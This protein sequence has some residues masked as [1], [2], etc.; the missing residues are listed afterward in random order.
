M[1]TGQKIAHYRKRAGLKQT[2]LAEMVGITKQLLYKY[3]NDKVENMPLDKLS[4]I[5]DAVHVHPS[6]LAGWTSEEAVE[7]TDRMVDII[8]ITR[9]ADFPLNFKALILL[10]CLLEDEMR[11]K[12]LEVANIICPREMK[13]VTTTIAEAGD[14]I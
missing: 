14:W 9:K 10:N 5:A 8:R 1:T 11:G 13:D 7:Q 12:L 2:E 4:K 6:V 3:E